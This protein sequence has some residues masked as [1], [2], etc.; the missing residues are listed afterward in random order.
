MGEQWTIWADFAIFVSVFGFCFVFISLDVILRGHCPLYFSMAHKA[1]FLWAVRTSLW[2]EGVRV[3]ILVQY[4]FCPIKIIK[5]CA[6]FR[7][8]FN[9]CLI[10]LCLVPMNL[11]TGPHISVEKISCSPA[12][13]GHLI[14]WSIPE[15]LSS[16][17]QALICGIW[18]LL[19]WFQV[20]H[21]KYHV[22]KTPVRGSQMGGG[23]AGFK[24]RT[25]TNHIHELEQHPPRLQV[26]ASI[27]TRHIQDSWAWRD[28][29]G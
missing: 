3:V 9:P 8:M 18:C 1:L 13:P 6:F 15:S 27:T 21:L 17:F 26:R 25:S 28:G 7:N 11:Q 12:I 23:E 20:G 2:T 24:A 19:N 5:P 22:M 10:S 14:R 4:T 16:Q 29:P